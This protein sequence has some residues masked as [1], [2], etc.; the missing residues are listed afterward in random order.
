MSDVQQDSTSKP[1]R[2]II[3]DDDCTAIV[4]GTLSVGLAYE[5]VGDTA[6]ALQMIAKRLI[7]LGFGPDREIVCYRGDD[8]T[9]MPLRDAVGENAHD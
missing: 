6:S 7:A 3:H 8:Q 1:V 2:V 9:R 5:D 4:D